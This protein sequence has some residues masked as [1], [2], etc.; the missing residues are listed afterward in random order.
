MYL[1]S[2]Y[3]AKYYISEAESVTIRLLVAETAPLISSSVCLAEVTCAL[4]RHAREGK[5]RLSEARDL[6]K[7][8]LEDIDSGFW[9]LIPVSDRILRSVATF[10]STIPKNVYIRAAD[11]LHLTTARNEGETEIWTNDRHLLA[12]AP[13]FGLAGR[14]V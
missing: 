3:V 8:F 11:A 2:A 7:V 1:D 9:T 10:V 4:H 13:Y 12:A 6:T 5:L 14:T